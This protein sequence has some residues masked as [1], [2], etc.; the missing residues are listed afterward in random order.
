M[1][2]IFVNT[3]G[4][5]P[6]TSGF[7]EKANQLGGLAKQVFDLV[8]QIHQAAGDDKLGREFA[9]QLTPQVGQFHDGVLSLADTLGQTGDSVGL[10]A[11]MFKVTDN[12]AGSQSSLLGHMLNNTNPGSSGGGSG[13]GSSGDGSGSGMPDLPRFVMPQIQGAPPSGSG[14]PDQPRVFRPQIQGPPSSGPGT[15]NPQSDAV[16]TP[17]SGPG[18]PLP[19]SNAV[20]TPPSGS[21][22]GAGAGPGAPH[23]KSDGVVKPPSG[24]GAR[25]HP[26]HEKPHPEHEKPPAPGAAGSKGGAR[27]SSDAPRVDGNVRRQGN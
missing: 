1:S 8:N 14:T 21:G 20:V 24:P 26:E 11:K 19:Q 13:S 7:Q 17:P 9:E 27:R 6:V 22:S 23:P 15:P 2:N 4:L 12:N 25:R 5:T 18:A 10:M 16:V 3:D